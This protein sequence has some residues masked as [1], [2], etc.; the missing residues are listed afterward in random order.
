MVEHQLV[1]VTLPSP[2][3]TTSLSPSHSRQENN[4][5][6]TKKVTEDNSTKTNALLHIAFLIC[7][8][9]QGAYPG[10]E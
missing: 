2:R 6:K 5:V 7:F 1:E 8:F 4:L 9:Y 3:A 10:Y